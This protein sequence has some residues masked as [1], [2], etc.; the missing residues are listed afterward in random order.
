VK[1]SNFVAFLKP[2]LNLIMNILILGSGGREHAIAWII[3]KS[4]LVKQIFVAPGNAG[5]DQVG[6]NI[7]I[8]ITDFE[9]VEKLV[10]DKEINFVI[11]GPED[12]IVKGIVDYFKESE[13]LDENIILAP[14]QAGA[15]LEGSKDFAKSFM[16]KYNIPTAAYKTFNQED[17]LDAQKYIRE[18]GAPIVIKADGLA[19]GK[20]V[21]VAQTVNEA[22]VALDQAFVHEKF[23]SAGFKV[24]VEEFLKGIE[25][26]VFVLTDG[27]NYMLLPEAKD[28]KQIGEGNTGP[29]TGGMGSISPV[30]FANAAFMK[31][32]EEKII[33]PTINGLQ[34][35]GIEYKG[36]I[37]FGL[38]NVDG[39]PY[40]IEYNVRL[41]D[42]E[43]EAILPRIDEDLLPYLI[44][45]SRK[46]LRNDKLKL[47]PGYSVTVMAVS[48]G[49][50]GSYEKGKTIN[51]L[52][53]V[54][55]CNLFISGAKK[56]GG[57]I[58]TSG[59]RVLAVNAIEKN[60]VNAL[61][62]SLSNIL[63]VDF[64]KKYYRRDIGHDLLN[65]I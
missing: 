44:N 28:Y 27:K 62:K 30:P 47:K 40:V 46:T 63:K 12:P 41:G 61:E 14:T 9:K 2:K 8:D 43:A 24:V 33:Q 23:G 5:T 17:Y 50:P 15:Q 60:F 10:L 54:E 58:V 51:G 21:T 7:D 25:L 55:D 26:S 32:V 4:S 18:K 65:Y 13:N 56:S 48:G 20:G 22:L 64:E 6:N 3:S 34:N 42:P 45:A 35:E 19:A 29:N 16:N 59:G 57:T 31:K 38:M 1:K 37:F 36:F 49:Y 52:S 53:E 39:E 11:V